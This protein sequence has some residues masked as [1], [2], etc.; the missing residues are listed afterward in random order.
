MSSLCDLIPGLDRL[1]T[2]N[3]RL[4]RQDELSIRSRSTSES[5][6]VVSSKPLKKTQFLQHFCKIVLSSSMI[7]NF[8]IAVTLLSFPITRRADCHR[9]ESN[10]DVA[11]ESYVDQSAP[12]F[13]RDMMFVLEEVP[14]TTRKNRRAT[15]LRCS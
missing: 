1:L 8:Y 9:R 3:Q 5:R 2:A 4:E 11:L 10:T 6:M 12:T 15:H 14:V 7:R 13:N